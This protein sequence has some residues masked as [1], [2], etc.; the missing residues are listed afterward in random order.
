MKGVIESASRNKKKALSK[1]GVV[2]GCSP[3]HEVINSLKEQLSSSAKKR[4]TTTRFRRRL[5][6]SSLN[7]LKKYRKQRWVKSNFRVTTK[8]LQPKKTGPTKRAICAETKQLVIAF[9]EANASQLADKK[10]ISKKKLYRKQLFCK[11]LL[12]H[13]TK[14]LQ[15]HTL[16]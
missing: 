7:V 16:M 12:L 5:L 6:A 8:L 15:R 11:S 1:V 14:H 4:D 9:Y 3:E 2:L 13:C 10:A